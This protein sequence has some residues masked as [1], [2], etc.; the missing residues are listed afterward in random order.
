MYLDRHIALIFFG[1]HLNQNAFECLAHRHTAELD[2][3]IAELES[4]PFRFNLQKTWFMC[5]FKCKNGNH[6]N[7]NE[8]EKDLIRYTRNLCLYIAWSPKHNAHSMFK[9]HTEEKL[10]VQVDENVR[11]QIYKFTK[12]R[13]FILISR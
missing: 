2:N 9:G 8:Y 11:F 13:I 3:K 10:R 6:E 12:I 5:V 7:P 4:R 1:A